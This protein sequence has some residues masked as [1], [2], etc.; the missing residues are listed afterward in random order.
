MQPDLDRIRRAEGCGPFLHPPRDV[1]QHQRR[2]RTIA[3][4][5]IATAIA[6]VIGVG[7]G[8]VS[9]VWAVKAASIYAEPLAGRPY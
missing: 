6:A 8:Y 1:K 9:T 2:A 4:V 7:A 5:I 3:L